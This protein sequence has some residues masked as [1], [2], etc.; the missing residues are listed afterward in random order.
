M[1]TVYKEH[2]KLIW[3][4]PLDSTGCCVDLS[5]PE[6]PTVKGWT[7]RDDGEDGGQCAEEEND[8]QYGH[9]E[10]ARAWEFEDVCMRDVAA[11]D[12]PALYIH[13]HL[14]FDEVECGKTG[15]IE[16]PHPEAH[17]HINT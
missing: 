5:V 14:Q 8:Q 11:H 16:C 17:T 10:V 13:G 9:V 3:E 6:R 15:G 7:Q 2:T 12:G 1:N 4:K